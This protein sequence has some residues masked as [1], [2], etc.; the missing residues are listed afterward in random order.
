M[1][2][3]YFIQEQAP[4]PGTAVHPVRYPVCEWVGDDG[5][6]DLQHPLNRFVCA[7]FTS[8]VNTIERGQEVQMVLT[9]VASGQRTHGA[10]DGDAFNVDVNAQGVQ[11]NFSHVGPDD[12][13][14]WNLPQG[15]FSI[16]SVC[17]LLSAWCQYLQTDP[18]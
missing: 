11:F 6:V 4:V 3:R 7:W 12:S 15:H 14:W 2:L 9:Q 17:E 1:P 10:V 8:D 5:Q 18:R 13:A 16:H